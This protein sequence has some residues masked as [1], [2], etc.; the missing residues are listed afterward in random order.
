VDEGKN[1]VKK[2]L[3]SYS[4]KALY[5]GINKKR[6]IMNW[7]LIGYRVAEFLTMLWIFLVFGFFLIAFNV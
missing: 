4:I 3:D 2:V 1:K 6:E 5:L 7:K